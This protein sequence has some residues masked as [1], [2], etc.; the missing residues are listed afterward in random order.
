MKAT[1]LAP[2]LCPWTLAAGWQAISVVCL[3][4]ALKG[5]RP[6]VPQNCPALALGWVRRCMA[7]GKPPLPTLISKV[8]PLLPP[9]FLEPLQVQFKM[10]MA[11]QEVKIGHSIVSKVLPGTFWNSNCF[12]F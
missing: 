4:G 9:P 12:V 2:Q 8:Y 3:L 7:A 11:S 5:V 1:L 6:T 10:Q